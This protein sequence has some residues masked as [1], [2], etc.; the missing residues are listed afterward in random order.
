MNNLDFNRRPQ[1]SEPREMVR[2]DVN[3]ILSSGEENTEPFLKEA[4]RFAKNSGITTNQLR[5]LYDLILD[6]KQNGNDLP[7]RQIAKILIKLEYAFRRRNIPNDFYYG[8]KPVLEALLR[9]SDDKSKITNFVDFM[10][11]VVAYSKK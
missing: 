6:L 8:I 7:K 4:D 2:L 11:A 10:E 9:N 5:D 3:L 1:R